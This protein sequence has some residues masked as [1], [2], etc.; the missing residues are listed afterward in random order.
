MSDYFWQYSLYQGTL[1]AS[2]W[3]SIFF[4]ILPRLSCRF[5][6]PH[7]Y[8]TFLQLKLAGLPP[9]LSLFPRFSSPSP[10]GLGGDGSD[11]H[12]GKTSFVIKSRSIFPRVLLRRCTAVPSCAAEMGETV[13]K[14]P[15]RSSVCF[16]RKLLVL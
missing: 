15:L 11:I 4:I 16:V 1:W 3:K 8:C 7:L 12:L 14:A 9:F 2:V 5:H 6:V 13:S 10:R